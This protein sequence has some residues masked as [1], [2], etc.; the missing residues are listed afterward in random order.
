MM[1]QSHSNLELAYR[2]LDSAKETLRERS[3]YGD[4]ATN[5]KQISQMGSMITGHP[6]TEA[7][8]CAFMIALKLSRLSA[9]D[10]DNAN[11]N[12]VDSFVDIVG[13]AA[14]ALE[15]LENGKEKG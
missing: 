3:R 13:Y 5:F 8:V 10:E 4:L 6:M 15:L 12:H 11:C 2:Y 14:I 9:K 1:T 7:Q